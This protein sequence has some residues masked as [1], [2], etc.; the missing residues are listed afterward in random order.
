MSKRRACVGLGTFGGIAGAGVL[1]FAIFL[2][3]PP[4]VT[5][6][7]FQRVKIGMSQAEAAA[8]FGVPPSDTA[9]NGRNWSCLH[10]M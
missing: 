6:A 5:H 9:P 4:G 7:N 10:D 2:P 1:V 3:E 8:A